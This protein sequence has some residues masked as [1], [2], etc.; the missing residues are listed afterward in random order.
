[1][2]TSYSPSEQSLVRQIEEIKAPPSL[3]GSEGLLAI[4]IGDNYES[5]G[6][7]FVTSAEM[8][9][10]LAHISHPAGHKIPAHVH[11]NTPRMVSRTM[12]TLII[13][14]GK[15]RVDFYTSDMNPVTSRVIG[16]GDAVILI[17][18]GHGFEILEP[19]QMIEVKQG[20]YNPENDKRRVQPS[21]DSLR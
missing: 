17:S 7:R 13:K 20:P 2:T 10:Q 16:T 8:S 14:R 11:Y 6:V 21:T 15:I 5:Q 12:E 3:D 4:I 19:T 9:Q 1:M 18:G